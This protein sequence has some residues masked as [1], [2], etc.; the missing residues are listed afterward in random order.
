MGRWPGESWL[1]KFVPF[2]KSR[3]E[4][5]QLAG[6]GQAHTGGPITHSSPFWKLLLKSNSRMVSCQARSEVEGGC[7]QR[8]GVD[9][10]GGQGVQ[11]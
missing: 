5:I 11:L 9:K 6:A 2:D 8:Y 1:L 4:E 3:S 7:R 10:S